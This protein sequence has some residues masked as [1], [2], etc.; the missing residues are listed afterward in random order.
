[1]S[2]GQL[3]YDGR[4][5]VVTGAGSGLGREYA[6]LLASRGASVLVSNRAA[7]TAESP[8]PSPAELVAAQIREAGGDAIADNHSVE[9]AEAGQ[10]IVDHALRAFG[11]VDILINNAGGV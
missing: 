2:A 6:K 8:G 3:S 4:V 11:R 1:M 7:E 5:A 10:A 9:S